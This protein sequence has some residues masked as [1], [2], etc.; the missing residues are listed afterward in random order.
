MSRS[1]LGPATRADGRHRRRRYGPLLLQPAEVQGQ[2]RGAG[3]SLPVTSMPWRRREA[4]VSPPRSALPIYALRPDGSLTAGDPALVDQIACLTVGG[5]Q[6]RHYSFATKY[7][8]WHQPRQFPIF[9]NQVASLLLLFRPTL[10]RDGPAA[11]G[12]RLAH[13]AR[14]R[15]LRP[16]DENSE[17]R[18]SHYYDGFH[19]TGDTGFEFFHDACRLEVAVEHV[20]QL[21][22]DGV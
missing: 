11:D 8:S 14:G 17:R 6:R 19:P 21:L 12:R 3:S 20:V 16:S 1:D 9:N 2:T 13:R 22:V 10:S 7:C 5:K 18:L 15:H 4:V